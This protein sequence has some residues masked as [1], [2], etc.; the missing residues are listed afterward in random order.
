MC[1]PEHIATAFD[2]Y[3]FPLPVQLD[4]VRLETEIESLIARTP[5]A[6]ERTRQLGLQSYPGSTDLWYDACRKQREIGDDR[7]YTLLHP[8]LRGSYIEEAFAALPFQ[9]FRARLMGI[10]PSVCYAIHSDLTPRYHIA[11]KTTPQ[12]RFVFVDREKLLHI[13]ADGR[14]YFVDTRETHTAFNAGKEMRLHIVFGGPTINRE[15]Q[16]IDVGK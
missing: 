15:G 5:L 6:F 8:E 10:D 13:P 9:P 11:V 14:V 1:T 12:A 4:I 16:V 3:F 2:E 7:E